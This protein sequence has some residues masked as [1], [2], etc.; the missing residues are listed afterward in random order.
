MPRTKEKRRSLF[1]TLLETYHKEAGFA[2]QVRLCRELNLAT[3]YAI[4]CSVLS[5]YMTG[6][7]GV[8]V[9]FIVRV[10]VV[11]KLGQEKRDLL[12]LSYT[13]DVLETLLVQYLAEV[14]NNG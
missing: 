8:P 4:D 1:G 6:A 5:K 12:F 10:A 7:H 14:G 2:S 11:L 9:S 3:D 13:Y